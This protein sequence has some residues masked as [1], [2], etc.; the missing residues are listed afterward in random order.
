MP[1]KEK[2]A[3]WKGYSDS[4]KHAEHTSIYDA[5]WELAFKSCWQPAEG[6]EE[7]YKA[8]WDAANRD[9]QGGK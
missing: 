2:E 9:R 1:N 4:M 7:A 5:V 3:Y 6:H 8:G